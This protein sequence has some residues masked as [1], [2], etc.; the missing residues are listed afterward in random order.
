MTTTPD[1][2]VRY[3]AVGYVVYALMFL[4]I[5]GSMLYLTGW[6]GWEQLSSD[7]EIMGGTLLLLFIG[8]VVNLLLAFGSWRVL[9]YKGWKKILVLSSAVGVAVYLVISN[10]IGLVRYSSGIVPVDLGAIQIVSPLAIAVGYVILAVLLV[11]AVK[12]SNNA[13]QR[14]AAKP[15]AW[16]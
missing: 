2:E 14:D 5:G 7:M 12:I 3:I 10:V 11:R 8:G 16:P 9:L 1:K 15:R 13:A 4:I 6:H